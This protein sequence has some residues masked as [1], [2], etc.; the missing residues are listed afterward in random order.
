MLLPPA[1]KQIKVLGAQ[2]FFHNELRIVLRIVVQAEKFN[3]ILGKRTKMLPLKTYDSRS[4]SYRIVWEL[5]CWTPS[6]CLTILLWW[7]NITVKDPHT[8]GAI[9]NTYGSFLFCYLAVFFD[10]FYYKQ[11]LKWFEDVDCLSYFR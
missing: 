11:S 10:L 4:A 6:A 5:R 9:N 7:H 2:I 3:I 1:I 8:V